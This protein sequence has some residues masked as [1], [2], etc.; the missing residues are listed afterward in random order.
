MTCITYTSANFTPPNRNP[1]ERASDFKKLLFQL[2][3]RTDEEKDKRLY[4]NSN[5]E[6][7]HTR[8]Q[9]VN[10]ASFIL[11]IVDRALSLLE[12]N[13]ATVAADYPRF[14]SLLNKR[15]KIKYL[16]GDKSLQDL[17]PAF[18]FYDHL[19]LDR[20]EMP[21][22]ALLDQGKIS[23]AELL[24]R[25]PHQLT[26]EE[27]EEVRLF[28]ALKFGERAAL[29]QE[30]QKVE[31]E[32]LTLACDK[33]LTQDYE[34]KIEHHARFIAG[35]H[36]HYYLPDMYGQ[37]LDEELDEDQW[38]Q[39][40]DI[41]D[42]SEDCLELSP[43]Q[44]RARAAAAILAADKRPRLKRIKDAYLQFL[45]SRASQAFRYYQNEQSKGLQTLFDFA[46]LDNFIT[47]DCLAKNH[48][49]NPQY[50]KLARQLQ[51][52]QRQIQN[53]YP[54]LKKISSLDTEP[55][56]EVSYNDSARSVVRLEKIK[57]KV[58]ELLEQAVLQFNKRYS[59]NYADYAKAYELLR[60][61]ESWKRGKLKSAQKL[62]VKSYNWQVLPQPKDYLPLDLHQF[63]YH[64]QFVDED[65]ARL[66]EF[67]Q[68][69]GKT[70]SLEAAEL[71]SAL[72]SDLP[73]KE[74]AK[75]LDKENIQPAA[76]PLN[77]AELI[78]LFKKTQ[79][80]LQQTPLF[81]NSPFDCNL[82]ERV[83]RW[84]HPK[85]GR[86]PFLD[87]DYKDKGIFEETKEWISFIHAFA[88]A[89]DRIVDRYG[90]KAKTLEK[91][92]S[93]GNT[94][95]KSRIKCQ[96]YC[97]LLWK[98]E[99]YR[100][101]LTYAYDPDQRTLFH[102]AF[103]ED[104]SIS[105]EERGE[106]REKLSSL[107]REKRPSQKPALSSDQ[108]YVMASDEGS[109]QIEDPRHGAFLNLVHAQKWNSRVGYSLGKGCS[110]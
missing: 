88:R 109:T 20:Q 101:E 26:A 68:R 75:E 54:E 46:K 25:K 53:I 86:D 18:Y 105:I 79:E 7:V 29:I 58:K 107:Q 34:I 23:L 21:V 102:R 9:A 106:L 52:F 33:T 5:L 89:A 91:L 65:V 77:Y 87:P 99:A 96:I 85:P 110:S 37:D 30:M 98:G 82:S 40:A 44:L 16:K 61:H 8:Q 64:Q 66:E 32:L 49:L 90:K 80:S 70:K 71:K 57:K 51:Q 43:A 4:F 59:Q 14:R 19:L 74:L 78:Q 24:N 103:K 13:I 104:K 55:G 97:E 10:R 83:T 108:S 93:F 35:S 12:A 39:V 100:G 69:K 15:F 1:Q 41:F 47:A 36:P 6:V 11:E 60:L 45:K 62:P 67:I 38:Q 63:V 94:A 81:Q 48:I 76:A 31:L 3:R 72:P 73:A 2:H 84:L 17:M 50:A 95:V 22:K 56:T 92:D 28:I 27:A 42:F